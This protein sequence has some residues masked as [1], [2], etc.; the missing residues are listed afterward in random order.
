MTIKLTHLLDKKIYIARKT[1]TTGDRL[2]YATVT[3]IYVHLQP[4]SDKNTQLRGG[5]FGKTWKIYAEGDANLQEGDRLRDD[6]NN[7]YKVVGAGVS[8]RN[9]SN[10]DFLEVIVELL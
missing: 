7:I 2:A 3:G 1:S 9:F 10:F 8:R 4:L 5:V 6:S